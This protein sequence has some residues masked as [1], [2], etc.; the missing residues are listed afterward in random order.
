MR[1][2]TPLAALLL[3]TH[4]A[5]ACGADDS[6]GASPSF[7]DTS[8]WS[9]TD[10]ASPADTW[11][12][13]YDTSATADAATP[14]D[15]WTPPPPPEDEVDY[16]L[17]TP[18]AGGTYLYIPSAGLDALVVIDATTLAVHLVEVGV[19]PALVRALPQDRGAVVLN[20]G[21]GD[22]SIVRPRGRGE[23]D[24][25]TLD[26]LP[27]HN[28]MVL[29]PD[30]AWA[31]V[32][33]DPTAGDIGGFGSLQ[34]VSAVALGEGE[35]VVYNLAVGFRPTEVHFTALGQ[36][37]LFFCENGISG[38]RL[39]ALDADTFLPPVAVD[40]NP[41]RKPI[42][43][44]IA[45]TPDG[46]LAVVRDL[47]ATPRLTLVDLE[48]HGLRHLALPDWPSDLD[49]TPDGKKVVVP[50]KAIEQ[51]ALV[52]VPEAFTWVAPEP[53]PADPEAEPP[54]NPF[55]TL[56]FTGARFGSAEL[57]ADGTR[58][59][60]FTTESGTSAIGMVDTT[61]GVAVTQPLAK[62][63]TSVLVSLDGQMAALLH[64][65]SSGTDPAL[66]GVE[67]YTLLD[68]DSGFAKIETV[69]HA[70][71]KVIFTDDSAELFV[72][73]PDPGGTEHLVHR[74]STR[75]FAVTPYATPD[76]PVF[77][78]A[79][80]SIHKVAIALDNPTGWITL[81]DTATGAVDQVNSFELNSFIK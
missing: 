14:N 42:D 37:A 44:E 69:G 8:S 20:A 16:D 32:W 13:S 10:A 77:V 48:V 5:S 74:V 25:R 76:A 34:D 67:A 28:R 59:L 6:M 52:Q 51:V 12:G 78:G 62:E 43:R 18:E 29:S 64:R 47:V 27:D 73:M 60:L 2:L 75:S 71:S 26:V 30:G 45:V 3:L 49:M 79:M 38:V 31:F 70:V 81:I 61:S 7:S 50:M 19:E 68:L 9:S 21:S 65:R 23:F 46:K 4:L 39:A 57:T 41:F 15:T 63:V 17:R 33:F 22:V 55:V 24:V 66:L 56:A 40:E 36:V 11:S 72:L 35:E 58:A 80:P 54:A 53:D 1:S